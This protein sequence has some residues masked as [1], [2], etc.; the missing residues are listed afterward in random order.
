MII[1]NNVVPFQAEDGI[2]IPEEIFD[3]P[4]FG[5]SIRTYLIFIQFDFLWTLNYFALLLLNFLE[6]H[7]LLYSFL[8]WP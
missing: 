3:L 8:S 4:S 7:N 1:S 6:V 2:G 5:S